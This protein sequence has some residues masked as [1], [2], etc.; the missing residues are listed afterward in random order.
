MTMNGLQKPFHKGKL[1]AGVAM[2][3]VA[4]LLSGCFVVGPGP[5]PCCC[6]RDHWHGWHQW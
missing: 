6:C 2:F 3:F 5:G 1:T 4:V